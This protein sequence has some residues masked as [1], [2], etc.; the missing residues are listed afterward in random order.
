MLTEKN[1]LKFSLNNY[2]NYY[3]DE[4]E[5][6]EDLKRFNYIKKLLSRYKK[7]GDL[8]ERLILN[9]IIILHNCFGKHVSNM[10]FMRCDE[11]HEQLKPFLEYLNLMPE[12]IE[13]ENEMIF[14][15]RISSDEYVTEKLKSI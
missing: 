4:G 10:L 8:K 6:E 7:T 3:A 9:H 1:F 5:F 15:Q 14:S 13:Y 12:I 11:F 2:K